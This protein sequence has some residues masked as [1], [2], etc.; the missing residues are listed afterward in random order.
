MENKDHSKEVL[1]LVGLSAI[2]NMMH[3]AYNVK[4][5][6]TQHVFYTSQLQVSATS[7]WPSS[8]RT[9]NYKKEIILRKSNGRDLR[10]TN[11]LHI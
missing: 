5:I 9:Q 3:D 8:D 2:Y 1:H 6:D 11:K 10:L 7:T 4:L